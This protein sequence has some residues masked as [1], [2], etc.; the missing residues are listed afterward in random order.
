[1]L[2][3]TIKRYFHLKGDDHTE[4]IMFVMPFSLRPPPKDIS[5]FEFNN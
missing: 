2:S 5:K 4:K 1:M 3:M